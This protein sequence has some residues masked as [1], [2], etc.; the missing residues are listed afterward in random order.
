MC[1]RVISVAGFVDRVVL[2]LSAGAVRCRR[3]VAGCVFGVGAR[4]V[5]VGRRPVGRCGAGGGSP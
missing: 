5:R 3:L 2:G 4:G 1:F